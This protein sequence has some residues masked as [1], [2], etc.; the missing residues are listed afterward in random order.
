MFFS[1][2]TVVA[3]LVAQL[4]FAAPAASP[5]TFYNLPTPESGPCDAVAGP[6]GALWVQNILVN[7]IVRIDPTTGSVQGNVRTLCIHEAV[8][9]LMCRYQNTPF[10]TPRRL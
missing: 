5:F 2:I 1:T 7:T 8:F 6:D 4:A 3:G 10:H 9:V